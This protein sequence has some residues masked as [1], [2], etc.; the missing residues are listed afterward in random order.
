MVPDGVTSLSMS[1]RRFRV[2]ALATVT[3]SLIAL[4]A[5]AGASGVGDDVAPGNTAYDGRFTFVRLSY[6][7]RFG[8]GGV[9]FG[10]RDLPWAHDYPRAER[11]LTKILDDISYLNPFQGPNGGNILAVG[12]PE[13]HK[14]PFAYMSEPGYWTQTD[15]EVAN[16]RSYLL[17][18]GFLVFDDFR[19]DHWYNFEAQ[20][21]RVLPEGQLVELDV[22][23][24]IFHSFFD[25]KTLE[26]E[27]MYNAPPTFWGVFEDND[28]TRRLMV[29]AN[30]DNDIGEYW[31]FDGAGWWAV[32]VTNE[33]YKFGVNYVVY[34]MTH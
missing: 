34:A 9:F 22:T 26:M 27:L 16:L 23:H 30:F 2:L 25:I 5:I 33:A 6:E 3:S 21:K 32:D 24:P 13:V 10:G 20:L 18:G 29:I 15:A 8:G 11:N 19:D 17:K 1:P 31:E 14:Y 7:M 28:P 4:G 12:D